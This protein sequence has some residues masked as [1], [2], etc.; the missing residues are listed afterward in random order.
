MPSTVDYVEAAL[1]LLTP[2]AIAALTPVRRRRL[3]DALY[4]QHVLVESQVTG[5]AFPKVATRL[6]TALRNTGREGLALLEDTPRSSGVLS[7]LNGGERS[8]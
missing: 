6:A 2:E 5:E 4:A 1:E 8:A 3:S 7:E